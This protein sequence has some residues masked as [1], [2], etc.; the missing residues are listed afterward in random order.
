MSMYLEKLNK[1]I[2]LI[3]LNYIYM[4]N[5]LQN[6]WIKSLS[7]LLFILII[8]SFVYI[9]RLNKYILDSNE[10][11]VI[12][13]YDGDTIQVEKNGQTFNVRYLGLDTPELHK[14]ETP[15]QCWAEESF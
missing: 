6:K 11:K 13:V 12:A 15:I 3:L 2:S 10:F 14:P 1:L 8:I 9:L 5:I 4:V 7:L